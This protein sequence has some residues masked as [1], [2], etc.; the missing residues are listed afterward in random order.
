MI[1][2]LTSMTMTCFFRFCKKNHR[3]IIYYLLSVASN[4]LDMMPTFKK[5]GENWTKQAI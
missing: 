5:F 4:R 2:R 3:L 1:R